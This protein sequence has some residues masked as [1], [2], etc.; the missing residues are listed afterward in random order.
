MKKLTPL[1]LILMLLLASCSHALY[2]NKYDWVKV[3]RQNAIVDSTQESFSN[4]NNVQFRKNEQEG[5]AIAEKVSGDIETEEVST[6][7]PRLDTSGTSKKE[8]KEPNAKVDNNKSSKIPAI[9]QEPISI[10]IAKPS[11]GLRN[12][13]L[14]TEDK[15]YILGGIAVVLLLVV[16]VAVGPGKVIPIL[17]AVGGIFM[18]VLSVVAII[19]FIYAICWFFGQFIFMM[20]H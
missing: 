1:A 8:R 2:K 3:D 4:L 10:N 13:R 11:P 14:T 6:P 7:S 17:I 12:S 20:D 16:I 5:K 18:A 9:Q 19:L 15:G